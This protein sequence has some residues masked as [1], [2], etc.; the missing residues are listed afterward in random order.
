MIGQINL[1]KML[2]KH[3]FYELPQTILFLGKRG[4]GKHTLAS[5]LA[6]HY[7]KQLVDMTDNISL[8]YI[9]DIYTRSIQC[10]YLVDLSQISIREQNVLL[11]FIEEPVKDSHIILLCTSDEMVIP[12]VLN[13]CVIY[14]FERY[15]KDS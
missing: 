2:Y 4:C 12:T 10:I 5:E 7:Q 15:S 13:R 14:E 9:E 6:A 3:S 1:Q 11:K 8:D